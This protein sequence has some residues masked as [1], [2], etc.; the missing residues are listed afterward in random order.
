MYTS[1]HMIYVQTHDND[2]RLL[3]LYFVILPVLHLVFIILCVNFDYSMSSDHADK[4]IILSPHI[5]W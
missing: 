5:I 3:L 1:V 4:N 2:V